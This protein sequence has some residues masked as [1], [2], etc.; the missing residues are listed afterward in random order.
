MYWSGLPTGPTSRRNF[1]SFGAVRGAAIR[2]SCG[3]RSAT[4]TPLAT[5]TTAAGFVVLGKCSLDS[6]FLFP[7]S[8]EAARIFFGRACFRTRPSFAFATTGPGG[9]FVFDAAARTAA[10][11]ARS[12]SEERTPEAAV[13]AP[14]PACGRLARLPLHIPSTTKPDVVVPVA[15]LVPEAAR[16]PQVRRIVVPR[17]APKVRS[18]TAVN[19]TP[20]ELAFDEAWWLSALTFALEA[21]LLQTSLPTRPVPPA[22]TAGLCR[23]AG[24]AAFVLDPRAAPPQGL[25]SGCHHH[26]MSRPAFTVGDGSRRRAVHLDAIRATSSN[27]SRRGQEVRFG[28]VEPASR[29]PRDWPVKRPPMKPAMLDRS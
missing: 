14:A 7:S 17:T 24:R 12:G 2:R 11:G 16:G 9:A 21:G 18:H 1:A 28:E 27:L 19:D 23:M 8:G 3:P 6:F 25:G 29:P 13:T 26:G 15:R 4:G 10:S 22:R 20:P 5:G